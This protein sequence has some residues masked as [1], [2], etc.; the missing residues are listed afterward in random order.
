LLV[1]AF[2]GLGYAAVTGGLLLPD[3]SY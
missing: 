3:I 1:L 2:A